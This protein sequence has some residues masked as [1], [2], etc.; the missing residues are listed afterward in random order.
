MSGDNEVVERADLVR[1]YEFNKGGY[2]QVTDAD[3]DA[4]EG[5][6]EQ[7]QLNHPWESPGTG[8]VQLTCK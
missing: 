6:G 7:Q 3:L 1:G 5:R 2:V 4:V 8:L